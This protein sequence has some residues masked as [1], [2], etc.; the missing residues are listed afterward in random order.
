[1]G[2]YEID[3]TQDRIQYNYEHRTGEGYGYGKLE[4]M[5]FMQEV[6]ALRGYY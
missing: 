5:Q 3:I 2:F 4:T 6:Q 1:M